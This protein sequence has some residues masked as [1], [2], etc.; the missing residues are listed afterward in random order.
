MGATT[1]LNLPWPAVVAFVKDGATAIRQLAEATEDAL[2]PPL[3]V[4]DG[5]GST[6]WS[7]KVAEIGWNA[8]AD[9]DR[10][11]GDW[12]SVGADD[13]LIIPGDPGYYLVA[14]TVRFGGKAEPDWYDLQIRTREQGAA[15]G[16]GT[17]WAG[18]RTEQ[19]ANAGS[20]TDVTVTGIVRIATTSPNPTGIAI[21]AAYNGATTPPDVGS[22][23]NSLSVY[24]LS[25]L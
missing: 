7:A 10:K 3:L 22:G 25:T 15:V 4:T 16:T 5:D 2:R 6:S 24:R 8:I 12:T 23:A 20:F 18:V 9:A 21:R 14:A 19:P 13:Q 17:R 1:K 11:R